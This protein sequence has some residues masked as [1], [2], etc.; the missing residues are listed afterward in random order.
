ML[1]ILFSALN[2]ASG[3]VTM[4]SNRSI[5]T[6]VPSAGFADL[7]SAGHLRR[8]AFIAPQGICNEITQLKV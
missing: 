8:W 6:D 1:A 2:V 3:R 5:D 7:Q 4:T